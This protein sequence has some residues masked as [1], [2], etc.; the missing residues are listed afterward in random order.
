[1][2]AQALIG[3]MQQQDVARVVEI[4][5]AEKLLDPGDAVFVSETLLSF[6]SIE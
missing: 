2:R 4:V 5:D 3:V 1:M 6:S